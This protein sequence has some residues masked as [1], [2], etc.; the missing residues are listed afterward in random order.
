MT[1]PKINT[2]LMNNMTR[3][4]GVVYERHSAEELRTRID[5]DSLVRYGC[6]RI[7]EGNRIRTA[8]VIDS[9][10]DA[11]DNSFLKV[12]VFELVD[13]SLRPKISSYNSMIFYQIVTPRIKTGPTSHIDGLSMVD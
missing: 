6:L 13:F 10:S 1:R 11:R 9:N 2:S 5:P 3:Y 4:F 7:V 8:S 12:R